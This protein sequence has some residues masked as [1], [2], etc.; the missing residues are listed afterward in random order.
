MFLPLSLSERRAIHQAESRAA[1]LGPIRG[2]AAELSSCDESGFGLPLTSLRAAGLHGGRDIMLSM[3]MHRY[4]LPSDYH[5]RKDDGDVREAVLTVDDIVS[6][7]VP[8]KLLLIVFLGSLP[9]AIS[10]GSQCLAPA[11]LSVRLWSRRFSCAP[12]VQERRYCLP[13]ALPQSMLGFQHKYSCDAICTRQV[14]PSL[15]C[16]LSVLRTSTPHPSAI[17]C[18]QIPI[19]VSYR[20]EPVPTAPRQCQ[21]LR[22]SPPDYHCHSSDLATILCSRMH[23]ARQLQAWQ[24]GLDI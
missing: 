5:S 22:S 11:R 9:R 23:I 8:M 17:Q 15:H 20:S 6:E 3:H 24:Q 19:S 7:L 10:V 21:A 13:W 2:A 16:T 12:N 1:A 18:I 4:V 14:A